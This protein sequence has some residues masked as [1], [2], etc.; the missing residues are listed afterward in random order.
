MRF[1]EAVINAANYTGLLR[2]RK[3][4]L[5][6]WT[7]I[8]HANECIIIST[9]TAHRQPE[10]PNK[11][12]RI[13]LSHAINRQE[14]IDVVLVGQGEPH[15]A[16]PRP[17][18]AYYHERLAKQYTE[19]DVDKA[20]EYLDKTGWTQ[21]DSEGF[22]LG[23]D[24]KRIFFVLEIDQ[25]RT[26]YVDML[27][28]I[29]PMWA[30]VGVEVMVKLMERSLWEERCRARNL[31]FH[32]TAHKFGGGSGES[33]ILDP[34]YWFPNSYSNCN[35]AKSWGAWYG[36]PQDEIAKEP[37]EDVKAAMALYEESRRTPDETTEEM[38]KQLLDMSAD[39]FYC[40]GT[41]TESDLFGIVTNRMRNTPD[42][43][44]LSWIYPTPGP[45]NTAQFYIEA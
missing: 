22:R 11:D 4:R 1:P 14:L 27:E 16:A 7:V 37:P 28:L 15:Q 24:G 44:P 29:K 26:V 42:W 45:I 32:G 40:I 33:P 23:P 34:R 20:N 9:A 2:A 41:S 19:Y 3:R 43:L 39:Q 31:E 25:S 8:E 36:N 21:R 5:H 30:A 12:F 6:F 13:G 18:S 17:E 38:L 10:W 35:Y